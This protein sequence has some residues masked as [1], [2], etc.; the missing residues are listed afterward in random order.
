MHSNFPPIRP[1]VEMGHIHPV[2]DSTV[3]GPRANKEAP[4]NIRQDED[5]HNRDHVVEGDTGRVLWLP[6]NQ[7]GV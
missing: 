3:Y 2:L 6:V 5:I 1:N 4:C 7:T